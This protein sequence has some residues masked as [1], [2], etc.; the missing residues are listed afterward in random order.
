MS[1]L[2]IFD[3]KNYGDWNE[4]DDYDRIVAQVFQGNF[5]IGSEKRSD[6][7]TGC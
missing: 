5:K 1:Y 7:L 3:E 6:P 2:Q 4:V